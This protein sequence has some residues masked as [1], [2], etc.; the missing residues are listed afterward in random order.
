MKWVW[1]ST[2]FWNLISKAFKKGT[3]TVNT[4]YWHLDVTD[5]F[6]KH[7]SSKLL[8]MLSLD[9]V[10]QENQFAYCVYPYLKELDL[11][12]KK[13]GS[14]PKKP[15]FINCAALQSF[16]KIAFISVPAAAKISFF[17]PAGQGL[18]NDGQ[19]KKYADKG[20]IY[21]KFFFTKEITRCLNWH[22]EFC[23]AF[24]I[25]NMHF[26]YIEYSTKWLWKSFG[27]VSPDV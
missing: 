3:L 23:V 13:N 20:F 4:E 12:L 21:R 26:E 9:T 19:S 16:E 17:L 24:E 8:S 15:F 25:W 6:R 27:N 7:W 11:Y 10:L 14:K 2:F 18:D 5:R 22:S 1:E